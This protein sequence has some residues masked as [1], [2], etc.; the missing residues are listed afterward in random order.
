MYLN[1]PIFK[2]AISQLKLLQE[3]INRLLLKFNKGSAGY[4]EVSPKVV[5]KFT[6]PGTLKP[7]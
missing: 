5:R 6:F 3:S 7:Q 2:H 4:V 1:S